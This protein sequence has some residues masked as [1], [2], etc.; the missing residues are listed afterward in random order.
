MTAYLAEGWFAR[1]GPRR[2]RAEVV[3]G[4]LDSAGVLHR[5]GVAAQ[6]VLTVAMR[7]RALSGLVDPVHRHVHLA[8]VPPS[9]SRALPPQALAVVREQLMMATDAAIALQTFVADCL[10]CVADLDALRGLQVHLMHVAQI[11]KLLT[12]TQKSAAVAALIAAHDGLEMTAQGRV[13]RLP[14]P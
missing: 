3:D 6:D 1:T 10:D 5:A 11:I 9:A 12:T 4:A 8:K 13:R 7:V 14:R 2:L